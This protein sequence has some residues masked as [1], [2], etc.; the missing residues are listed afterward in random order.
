MRY[1]VQDIVA[2]LENFDY[3]SSS[4]MKIMKL[5]FIKKTIREKLAKKKTKYTKAELKNLKLTF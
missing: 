4:S 2:N 3:N 5:K 1:Y